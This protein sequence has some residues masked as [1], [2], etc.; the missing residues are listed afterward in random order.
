MNYRI[1]YQFEL[2][3]GILS[4]KPRRKKIGWQGEEGY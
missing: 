1:P 4:R 2:N 3:L